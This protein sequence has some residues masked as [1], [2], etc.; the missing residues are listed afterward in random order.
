MTT[1]IL[2]KYAKR[3]PYTSTPS[4]PESAHY[5]FIKGYWLNGKDTLVSRGSMYGVQVS[6]KCDQET[7]EDQ[8]GE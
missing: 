6:K 3:K 1:H 2:V 5:D 4:M 8:K 7:G